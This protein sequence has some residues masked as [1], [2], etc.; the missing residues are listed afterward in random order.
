M[1][2]QKKD[3]SKITR[4]RANRQGPD[5]VKMQVGL[6]HIDIA[7]L[8]Q[9]YNSPPASHIARENL[10]DEARLAMMKYELAEDDREIAADSLARSM[11]M[12][13]E[14]QGLKKLAPER[15]AL[16][17]HDVLN[18][19]GLCNLQITPERPAIA[20]IVPLTT[21]IIHNHHGTAHSL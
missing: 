1:T 13:L 12:L 6:D 8:S 11:H 10:L 14:Q 20:S 19:C 7:A 15:M 4:L 3:S 5:V 9:L 21:Q 17:E 2:K 18:W 16:L